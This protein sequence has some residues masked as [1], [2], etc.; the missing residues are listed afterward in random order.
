MI[1]DKRKENEQQA[2]TPKAVYSLL[3]QNQITDI[4]PVKED[5]YITVSTRRLVTIPDVA[6]NRILVLPQ[7]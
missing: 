4:M 5:G 2:A 6:F 3:F 7:L 1:R